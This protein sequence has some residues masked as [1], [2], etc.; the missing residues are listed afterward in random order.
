MPTLPSPP[1]AD[2]PLASV[3]VQHLSLRDAPSLTG[4]VLRSVP[5]G[6]LVT[7]LGTSPDGLWNHVHYDLGRGKPLTGWMAKKYL[8][9]PLEMHAPNGPAEE[10]PWMPIALSEVGVREDLSPGRSTARV[11][12]YLRSTDLDPRLA[13]DDATPWCSGFANWCMEKSGIAGTNSAAARSWLG[14]GRELK[15]PRRGVVTVLSRGKTG[16]HVGFYIGQG[17]TVFL[18][19]GG[20]RGVLL[21]GGNQGNQVGV[22]EYDPGRVLGYRTTPLVRAR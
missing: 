5:R 12:E 6:H 21:L 11:V 7:V 8:T 19:G 14:W 9:D 10:F 15:A 13:D 2:L 22:S 1:L 20:T 3:N 16:G 4:T 17:D 18:A